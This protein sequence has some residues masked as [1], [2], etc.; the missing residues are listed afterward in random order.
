M[1]NYLRS[2]LTSAAL[3][4]QESSVMAPASSADCARPVRGPSA[5]LVPNV[6]VHT[7]EYRKAL[8]YDDLLRGKIVLAHCMATQDEDSC[9]TVENLAKVQ[10]LLGDRLGR[11]IF[12][13]SITTDPE[14]DTPQRLRALAEK[15]GARPGWLFLSGEPG[16]L[17]RLRE[18]FFGHDAM[19]LMRYGNEAV[20]LW[21]GLPANAGAE[22]IM[23]RLSWV[24]PREQPSGPPR[25]RGPA[26]LATEDS[27]E[28][29]GKGHE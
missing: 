10:S 16:A 17:G 19:R 29:N 20:G 27:E 5:R 18:K 21:G 15:Y 4:P 12:I 11:D 28:R 3:D 8:F 7:H 24:Q 25:R 1:F 23:E 6:V 13:Y 14:Y 26:P 2:L 22:A 9:S